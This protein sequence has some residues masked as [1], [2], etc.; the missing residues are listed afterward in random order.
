MCHTDWFPQG[1]GGRGERVSKRGRGGGTRGKE[2]GWVKRMKKVGEKKGEERGYGTEE[3]GEKRGN[4]E[5]CK[6][7]RL[8]D[9]GE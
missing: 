8:G 1:G 7:E 3:A 4:R 2:E 5:T 6:W 9:T